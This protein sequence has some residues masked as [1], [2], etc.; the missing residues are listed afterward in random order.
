MQDIVV[1][2]EIARFCNNRHCTHVY[3]LLLRSKIDL[4]SFIRRVFSNSLWI[5]LFSCSR[6]NCARCAEV[7]AEL[8]SFIIVKSFRLKSILG[9]I[10]LELGQ[11]FGLVFITVYSS[12]CYYASCCVF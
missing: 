4:L 2:L 5:I 11:S 3:H 12:Y 1:C 10:V 8:I 7:V 9:N 6:A